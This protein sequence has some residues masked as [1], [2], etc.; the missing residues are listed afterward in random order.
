MAHNERMLTENEAVAWLGDRGIKCSTRTLRTMRAKREIAFHQLT[1][2]TPKI[3]FT[4]KQLTEAF[5]GEEHG[6]VHG[7]RQVILMAAP[8]VTWDLSLGNILQILAMLLA[9]GGVWMDMSRRVERIQVQLEVQE[10]LNEA[11]ERQVKD[12][13]VKEAITRARRKLR[14]LRA[15]QQSNLMNPGSELN[16]RQFSRAYSAG[17]SAPHPQSIA[18][19]SHGP[20]DIERMLETLGLPDRPGAA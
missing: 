10:E 17:R 9:A 5:V 8:R 11:L 14:L 13:E 3:R 19:A 16:P 6:P 12:P 18:G 1:R 7:D 2:G 20:D 15:V 4:P